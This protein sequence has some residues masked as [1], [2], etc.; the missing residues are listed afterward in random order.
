VKVTKNLHWHTFEELENM[1]S[2][3][4]EGELI[5]QKLYGVEDKMDNVGRRVIR[6]FMPDQHR[7]FYQDLAVVFLGYTD[8]KGRAWSTLLSGN[9]G[10]IQSPDATTLEISYHRAPDELWLKNLH[11]GQDVGL[12]GLEFIS[13]R[14]NRLSVKVAKLFD[15]GFTLATKQSFGNCPRYISPKSIEVL[16]FQE[17]ISSSQFSTLGSEHR[18]IIMESDTFF[19]SSYISSKDGVANEGVDI[20][21]RGGSPGFV[22]VVNEKRLLIPD[23]S[24]NFHFN[25]L[26][27]FLVNSVCGMLFIDFTTGNRLQMTGHATILPL[28]SDLSDFPQAERLWQF[29]LEEGYF[30]K[31]TK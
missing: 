7:E 3:F 12:L 26:G 19:V 29:D 10:F 28:N 24:G 11:L 21:H 2:P 8:D 18:Q 23:Y 5:L 22:K 27:N 25:T 1:E 17:E 14:R 6:S 15:G 16:K 4:H 13:R 30:L 9:K 20:S 31:F